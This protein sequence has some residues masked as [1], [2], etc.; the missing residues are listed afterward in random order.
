MKRTEDRDAGDQG[1]SYGGFQYRWNYDEYQRSLQ[2]RRKNAAGKGLRA[3]C[4]TAAFVFLLSF[5]SFLAVI[6]AAIAQ[7]A[8]GYP[9]KMLPDTHLE[10]TRNT[11][12]PER[13]PGTQNRERYQNAEQPATESESGQNTEAETPLPQ[14]EPMQPVGEDTDR[15]E[16][17]RTQGGTEVVSED[18]SEMSDTVPA[19]SEYPVPDT[20]AS[21]EKAPVS[22][23]TEETSPALPQ[24]MSELS[25]IPAS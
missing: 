22:D 16:N 18:P 12:Q 4:L 5:F 17:E 19:A 20:G 9:E 25:E 8:D 23:E 24:T 6:A 2:K 1:S 21:A 3:F 10:G 13:L 15:A 7:Q 14:T 11:L